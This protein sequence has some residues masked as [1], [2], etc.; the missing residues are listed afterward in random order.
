MSK[1]LPLVAIAVSW[2]FSAAATAADDDAAKERQRFVGE[3]Q[4]FVVEGQGENPNRG[5]VKLSLKITA[6]AIVAT[7]DKDGDLGEGNF[8]FDLAAKPHTI[9][10]KRTKAPGVGQ[11]FLGIYELEGDTLKW[12][13]ATPKKDRPTEF[14]SK[15]GQYLMILKRKQP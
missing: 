15:S 8:S 11:M 1:L 5:P 12:C 6:E 14:K 3:W 4:G 7:Q 2:A 9:D 10:A 13:S